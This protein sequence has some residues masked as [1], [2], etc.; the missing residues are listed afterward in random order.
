MIAARRAARRRRSCSV[1][2][3]RGRGSQPT[4]RR[5]IFEP[6]HH[7]RGSGGSGLGLAI[8]R[9]FVDANGGRI[10]VEQAPS[11]GASFVIALPAA[12]ADAGAR[13]DADTP[14]RRRRAAVPPHARDQPAR[15]GVRGRDRSDGRGGAERRRTDGRFD[16]VVLDLVLP[17]GSG[18]DVCVGVREWSDVPIVVVSAVGEEREKVE[19]LDAGADDYVVKPF[20]ARRAARASPRG[21]S[22]RR[23]VDGA[24]PSARRRSRSTAR[25]GRCAATASSS[26]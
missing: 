4:R 11:G 22:P 26:I 12:D 5:A 24:G 7:G 6:F 8:A 20:R 1:S 14:C 2:T 25:G 21:A 23:T 3:T 10:W 13:R 19:A 15:R 9:G 16:A 17:D 18:K